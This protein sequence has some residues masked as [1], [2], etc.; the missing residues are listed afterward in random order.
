[1]TERLD[2]TASRN[3]TW[4]PSIDLPY[5]GGD[6]PLD[7]AAIALQWR[8]YEGAPGAALV[9]VES[10]PFVDFRATDEDPKASTNLRILRLLPVVA[11][12]VLEDLPTGRNHPEPGEADR[13][14]WDAIITYS[15]GATDRPVEG[16][17][18]LSKGTTRG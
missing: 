6:L 14:V 4:Q 8:L 1:M 7:G 2:L 12:T 9:S 16:F 13:Y 15:D 10:C 3:E 18:Y 5:R 11:S 17:V